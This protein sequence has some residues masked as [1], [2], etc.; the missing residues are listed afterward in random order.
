MKKN[1]ISYTYD[2]IFE[3]A[4]EKIIPKYLQDYFYDINKEIEI[5]KEKNLSKKY[6]EDNIL[7]K[8]N[9]HKIFLSDINNYL[10]KAINNFLKIND[11]LIDDNEE[12]F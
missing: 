1:S 10:I 3:N 7:N 9:D 2:K 11:T 4:S 8:V 6:I 12:D 5:C